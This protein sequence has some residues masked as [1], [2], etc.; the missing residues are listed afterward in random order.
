MFFF[1]TPS[2]PFSAETHKLSYL[3]IIL[4]ILVMDRNILNLSSCRSDGLTV[5]SLICII[6]LQRSIH[7]WWQQK[8]YV[9]W[10]E[11]ERKRKMVF[12]LSL[13]KKQQMAAKQPRK[14]HRMWGSDRGGGHIPYD[15]QHTMMS[16]YWG[17]IMLILWHCP[18]NSHNRACNI[19]CWVWV[20]AVIKSYKYLP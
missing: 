9:C 13:T 2:F 1:S 4:T 12:F 3:P 14:T 18:H 20:F 5:P 19:R 10:E 6:F 15:I 17:T 7:L 8:L 16:S 11:V